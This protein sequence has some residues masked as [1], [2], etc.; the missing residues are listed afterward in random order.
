MHRSLTLSIRYSRTLEPGHVPQYRL[1]CRGELL[2][3]N[4]S[5]TWRVPVVASHHT[6][7]AAKVPARLAEAVTGL[8]EGKPL[9]RTLGA[10]WRHW[11]P[12][13]RQCL[14]LQDRQYRLTAADD[15]RLL[16]LYMAVIHPPVADPGPDPP[17]PGSPA[18]PCPARG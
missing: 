8:R 12:G 5:G 4:G 18:R 15:P 14:G 9:R 3:H 16:R 2:V 6:G 11:F 7:P 13:I 17:A 10:D 1:A